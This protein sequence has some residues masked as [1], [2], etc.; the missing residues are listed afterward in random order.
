M[1]DMNGVLARF[2]VSGGTA[3]ITR[4]DQSAIALM[5]SSATFWRICSANYKRVHSS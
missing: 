2:A 3:E 1:H 5:S 4:P